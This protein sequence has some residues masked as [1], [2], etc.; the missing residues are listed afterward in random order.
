MKK[1]EMAKTQKARAP[2]VDLSF[3][4]SFHFM[5]FFS[6]RVVRSTLSPHVLMTRTEVTEELLDNM[7]CEKRADTGHTTT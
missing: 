3:G 7:T 1:N 6:F 5:S 2:V 4:L